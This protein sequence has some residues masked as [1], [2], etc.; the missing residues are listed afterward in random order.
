[1]SMIA[2]DDASMFVLPLLGE[3]PADKVHED[4][5]GLAL[6]D[7]GGLEPVRLLTAP[8]GILV[9]V[10][11]F[12]HPRET[13]CSGVRGGLRGARVRG[14]GKRRVLGGRVLGRMTRRT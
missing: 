10:G 11:R 9:S 1:M 7:I 4:K 12:L 3:L 8:T 6:H 2:Y 14:G 13:C 5:H